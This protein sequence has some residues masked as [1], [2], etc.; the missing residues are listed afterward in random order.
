MGNLELWYK[1]VEERRGTKLTWGILRDVVVIGGS[2]GDRSKG[3][4][5]K[6]IVGESRRQSRSEEGEEG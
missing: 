3:T 1:S 6:K 5:G 2:D 4:T